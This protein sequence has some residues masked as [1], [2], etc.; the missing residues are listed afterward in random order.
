MTN[1]VFSSAQVELLAIFDKLEKEVARLHG[2][3]AQASATEQRLNGLRES[4]TDFAKRVEQLKEQ[5]SGHQNTIAE[6]RRSFEQSKANAETEARRIIA[7]AKGKAAKAIADA[8][9]KAE[10]IISTANEQA[11]VIAHDI[12]DGKS[13][14]YVLNS[15]INAAQEKLREIK[16]VA[17]EFAAN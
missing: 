3:D 7:D 5:I 2:L 8:R 12:K 1:A 13:E 10:E 15:E 6:Q 11:N 16:K 4:H 9:A 14:L 17:A